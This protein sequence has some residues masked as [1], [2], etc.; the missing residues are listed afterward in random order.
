MLRPAAIRT[1]TDPLAAAAVQSLSKLSRSSAKHP[2]QACRLGM[3]LHQLGLTRLFTSA[4]L[5]TK[6]R[7]E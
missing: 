2:P 7:P 3:P 1:S 5:T 4:G 6:E